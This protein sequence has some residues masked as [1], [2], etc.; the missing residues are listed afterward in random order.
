MFSLSQR[1][2]EARPSE[3]TPSPS[4]NEDNEEWREDFRKSSYCS[5][6]DA[7]SLSPET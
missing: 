2:R 6:K 3:V 5:S 1:V 7:V 4:Y